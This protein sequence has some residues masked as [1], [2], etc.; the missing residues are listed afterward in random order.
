MPRVP[1]AS[2]SPA[3]PQVSAS[4][5]GPT[6]GHGEDRPDALALSCV[7]LTMGDRPAELSRAVRSVL[8]QAG[9]AIETVVV[10]IGAAPPA[11]PPEVKTVALAANVGIPAGRN[12]GV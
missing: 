11:L 4:P 7:I 6:P 5:A 8:D 2:A 12:A 3:R 10:A 1:P 9:P